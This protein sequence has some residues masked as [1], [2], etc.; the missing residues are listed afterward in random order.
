MLYILTYLILNN[1]GPV[2]IEDLFLGGRLPSHF[3][4]M[5]GWTLCGHNPVFSGIAEL[6]AFSVY[7]LRKFVLIPTLNSTCSELALD[8]KPIYSLLYTAASAMLVFTRQES[9]PLRRLVAFKFG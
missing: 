1:K 4:A 6:V 8:L 7:I 5:D 2:Y 3:K 9:V